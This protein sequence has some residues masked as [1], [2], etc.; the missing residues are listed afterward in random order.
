[1]KYLIGIDEAGRGP[2]AGPVAVGAAMVPMDF[3]WTL[4]RGAKDSKQLSAKQRE[5][6]FTRMKELERAGAMSFSV[7]FSS[8]QIIEQKGIV[9]AVQSALNRALDKLTKDRP[10]YTKVGPL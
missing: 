8:V 4:V 5:E 9:F 2:L 7:A 6:I 1:M 10:L 3:D